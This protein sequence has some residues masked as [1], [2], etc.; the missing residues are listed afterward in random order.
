MQEVVLKQFKRPIF[1]GILM[2]FF[3]ELIILIVFG[4]YLF[5]E[6]NKIKK[7]IWTLFFCGI[8]MGA[9]F[10]ALVSVIVV[11]KLTGTKAIITSSIIVITVLFSCN[12]LCFSLDMN[13]GFFGAR[14]NP[15]MFLLSG[16]IP[17]TIGAVV[18][19]V[20]LFTSKGQTV[21]SKVGL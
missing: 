12:V 15:F 9:T 8:G 20:L 7:L 16:F 5:P 21:L 1:L 4:F 2:T 3:A 18:Y 6:G 10:G 19:S 14:S 11:G 13:F 17:S